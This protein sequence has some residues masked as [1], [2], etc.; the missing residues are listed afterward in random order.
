MFHEGFY[1]LIMLFYN[2]VLAMRRG[3]AMLFTVMLT[4]L[5]FSWTP[6]ASGA[7]KPK[8]LVLYDSYI[9]FSDG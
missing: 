2:W 9:S 7:V 1:C 3:I 5:V 6:L 4:L 8:V